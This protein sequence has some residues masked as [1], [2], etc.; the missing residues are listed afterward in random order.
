MDV[1]V[2]FSVHKRLKILERY[3]P[4]KSVVLS[5]REFCREFRARKTP[6]RKMIT[7]I[8]KKFRNTGSVGNDHKGHSGQYV[9]ARTGANVQAEAKHLEQSP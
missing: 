2:Q 6:C 9:T 1:A 4:T 8:V 7:K 5:Q 3:C